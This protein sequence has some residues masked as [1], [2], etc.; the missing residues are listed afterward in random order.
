MDKQKKRRT[1]AEETPGGK[2]LWTNDPTTI[3]SWST[4]CDMMMMDHSQQLL[5]A[6]K[7]PSK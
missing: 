1:A 2:T 7:S 5:L 4:L 3:S 6:R